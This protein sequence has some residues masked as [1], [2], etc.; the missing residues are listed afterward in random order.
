MDVAAGRFAHRS[1]EML[2]RLASLVEQSEFELPVPAS[3]LS[4]KSTY[5]TLSDRDGCEALLPRTAFLMRWFVSLGAAEPKMRVLS[6]EL[7]R[8]SSRGA[9]R[10]HEPASVSWCGVWSRRPAS[11]IRPHGRGSIDVV[12]PYKV[13][14]LTGLYLRVPRR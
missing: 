6:L 4:Y 14:T 10:A 9:A 2:Q 7:S 1:G 5:S 12:F 8:R 13:W 3:K 11:N